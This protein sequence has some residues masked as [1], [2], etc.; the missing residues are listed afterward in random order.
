MS[1]DPAVAGAWR[2]RHAGNAKRQRTPP[3]SGIPMRCADGPVSLFEGKAPSEISEAGPR[4]EPTIYD[5]SQD[6]GCEPGVGLRNS[7]TSM[8]CV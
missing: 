3:G 6:P 1:F 5:R 8:P 4:F 7:V 2:G